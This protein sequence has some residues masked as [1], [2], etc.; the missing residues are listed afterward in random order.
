LATWL[1][2]LRRNL[3]ARHDSDSPDNR[4][5]EMIHRLY[6]LLKRPLWRYFRPVISGLE[7]IP[8]GPG[9]YVGNHNGAMLMPDV[10]IFGAALYE[11]FGVEDLPHGLA[12]SFG[13]SLPAVHQLLTRLGALRGSQSNGVKLLEAG[14]KVWIY[15]GGEL[16]SMRSFWR[17]DRV[18]FGSRRGYIRL[19]LRTGAPIIPFVVAGA[20][21]TLLVLDDGRWLARLL[22]ID[23]LLGVKTWPIVLCLPWGLWIGVPPPHFP[24]PSRV[25][26]EV[27][28]P[29]RFDRV[30]EQASR[31]A[32]YV[33]ACHRL[34]H[35]RMEAALRRLLA[36]RKSGNS[37]EQRGLRS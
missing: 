3:I 21:E 10:L 9:I 20:H 7:R 8:E 6:S 5:P 22:R 25:F 26:V 18:I 16:D 12:H 17:R 29:I 31:Q 35:G 27:L 15:P 19:A 1:D 30:G 32:D 33:E 13:I 28:E 37:L 11:R 23:R 24:L 36:R 4:D 2:G 14:R 34:V